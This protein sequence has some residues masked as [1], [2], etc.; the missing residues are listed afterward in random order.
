MEIL[1]RDFLHT[2]DNT[3]VE[4]DSH[5]CCVHSAGTIRTSSSGCS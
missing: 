4:P 5:P 1:V 3:I 2:E